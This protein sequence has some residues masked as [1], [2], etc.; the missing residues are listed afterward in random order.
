M[1]KVRWVPAAV[2]V[3]LAAAA[4]ALSGVG[5]AYAAG[6]DGN[7]LGNGSLGVASGNT[8]TAPISA[9][10]NLCGVSLAVLGFSSSACPG[11][12]FV[13][14]SCG[15]PQPTTT[16]AATTASGTTTSGGTTAGITPAADALAAPAGSTSAVTAAMLASTLSTAGANLLALLVAGLGAVGVGVGT[17]VLAR[18]RRSGV[19][20]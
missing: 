15:C 20:S 16:P 11:G 2:G 18:R 1:K 9:P 17:V 19:A 5:V 6:P 12:A 4:F 8:I 14:P 3:A 10:V 13:N 7:V